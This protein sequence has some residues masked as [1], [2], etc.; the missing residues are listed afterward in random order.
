MTKLTKD[1][2][3]KN[4]NVSSDMSSLTKALV[5][6]LICMVALVMFLLSNNK[7]TRSEVKDLEIKIEHYYKPLI[8]F[9][10]KYREI[11][12]EEYLNCIGT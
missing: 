9:N 8:Q 6:I 11:Y 4:K 10:E 5:I 12:F 7:K 1:M 2:S 3:T